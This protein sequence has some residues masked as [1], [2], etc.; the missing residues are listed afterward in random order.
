[1][2]KTQDYYLLQK[3]VDHLIGFHEDECDDEG[4]VLKPADLTN[5]KK[6]LDNN[7]KWTKEKTRF[8]SDYFKRHKETQKPTYLWIGCS[9]S[10]LPANEILG[11]DYGEVFVLRNVANM[12][13]PSDISSLAVI[14][15]AVE[16]LQVK[17]I[18]VAGHYGCG[19]VKA[20]VTK[21]N[22]GPLEAWLSK[23]RRI[24]HKHA[25]AFMH[26][27]T[28]DEKAKLLVEINVKEQVFNVAS[29]PFVQQ[30]WKENRELRIHGL[31][32]N[33]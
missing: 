30:A 15:Y 24:R 7:K 27:K 14:Q 3:E 21:Y 22:H 18:I 23:L 33:M 11:L 1:M 29:T 8:D 10:R 17:D 19:G 31:V 16:V 20:A 6:V 25:H 28:I 4:H 32:F 26:L 12:V 9:D 5:L 13:S 2:S